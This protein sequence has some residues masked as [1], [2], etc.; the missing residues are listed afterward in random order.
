[1]PSSSPQYH[2][3][4]R[5]STDSL[6]PDEFKDKPLRRPRNSYLRTVRRACRL[7]LRPI[8]LLPL[9]TIFL[10]WQLLLNAS[11]TSPPPFTVP[12]HE[13]VY[14]AANIIDGD[15]IT[16]AWGR[17]LLQLVDLIGKE[18]VFVSIYGGPTQA[19]EQLGGMLECE[20]ALVSESENPLDMASLPRTKLP[21][22]ESRVK[23]IAYLAEVRNKAL[24]PLQTGKAGDFDKVL[25]IN[26]V[27]FDA[28]DATRLIWGTNVDEKTGNAMYKA[29][30]G[31]DFVGWWKM[32][33]TFATRD[34]EGYSIGVPIFPW[35]AGEGDAISRNDVLAGKDAVRVKSC[36]GGITA[37]DARYLQP[38]ISSPN[39]P[40]KFRSEPEP[41]WDSSECCLIHADIMAL[42]SFPTSPAIWDELNG[43]DKGIYMN[44]HVRVSYDAGTQSRLHFARR[45]ERLFS[46]IQRLA[47][48]LAKMPVFNARRTEIEGE[49]IEDKVWVSSMAPPPTSRS[50]HAKRATIKGTPRMDDAYWHAKG[51]YVTANRT[52][53]RGA[54]CGVRQLLVVKEVV[55]EGEGNWDNLMYEVPPLGL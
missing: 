2:I 5:T 43:Y 14:I 4:P 45:V 44:P 16:G 23:R 37:F 55:G 50:A 17:S 3:L 40:L 27:Y 24:I 36:W 35:F 25:F 28:A 39:L 7:C 41:F 53:T 18:R 8:Y 26:D 15:L 42:P 52:A 46:P 34:A 49:I 6:S 54:Y 29:A 1:M 21:T 32:Y 13:R 31:A 38:Q 19:L 9:L 11:Y 20:H 33:D 12:A 51:H 30:C 10:L 47:N 48:W 22:G